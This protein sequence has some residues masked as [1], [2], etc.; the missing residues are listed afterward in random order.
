[1][2]FYY[3]LLGHLIGDFVLQ[4]NR[5]A[6]N[7]PLHQKWNAIHAVIVTLCM[8]VFAMPFGLTTSLLVLPAGIFHLLIDRAKP[9]LAEK[10]RIP[11]LSAFLADQSAHI[12]IIAFISNFTVKKAAFFYLDNTIV[13]FFLV[14]VSVTSFAAIL[15][16]Y[17]IAIAFPRMENLFFGEGEKLEGILVRFISTL[18]MFIS[19]KFSFLFLLLLPAAP[20]IL[21]LN[22][23]FRVK[24]R[25]RQSELSA[26]LVLDWIVS[27]AG[28]GVL[29]F[30]I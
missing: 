6:V 23:R 3:I 22:P 12:I 17:I 13:V 16:Q 25:E 24:S 9:F 28:A 29:C 14:L 27:A 10:Y 8:L 19:I 20:A 2:A 30:S 11:E 1:V 7:K 26:R 5:I 21:F 15:N 18:I 4:T